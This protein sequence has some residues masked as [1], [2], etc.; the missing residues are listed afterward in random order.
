MIES[1]FRSLERENVAYLLI[2]G[3]A[4]IL[5]GAAVFSEDVDLWVRPTDANI[6]ALTAALRA[7]HATYYKLTPHLSVR[8]MT[9][10]HGFHFLIPAKPDIFLDVM[11]QPPRVPSFDD[12]LG[13]S[14]VMNTVWGN[15]PTIGIKHLAA[16][17]STQRL[18]DYPI[19]SQL[20]L[21]YMENAS[22]PDHADIAWAYANLHTFDELEE[23]LRAYPAARTQCEAPAVGALAAAIESG[24]IIDSRTRLNVEHWLSER[25]LRLREDDRGY[26]TEI[27]GELRQLRRA[28]KLMPV[29]SPV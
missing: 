27:I 2:S 18:G 5:Y 10:G 26:W 4:T 11:G 28:G 3:Q 15:I 25:I 20:V 29:G 12:V 23:F 6:I 16:L 8:H 19:I 21:R 24:S 1:F 13:T 14:T 17:K 9:K 7:V 22:E